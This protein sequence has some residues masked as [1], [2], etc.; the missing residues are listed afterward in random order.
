MGQAASSQW[1]MQ[2]ARAATT[3]HAMPFATCNKAVASQRHAQKPG[4]SARSGRGAA[5]QAEAATSHMAAY[6]T[7]KPWRQAAAHRQVARVDE[8]G[9]EL[10][11]RDDECLAVAAAAE[12]LGMDTSGQSGVWCPRRGGDRNKKPC[13]PWL[14]HHPQ[15]SLTVMW[16]PAALCRFMCPTP[17]AM[18]RFMHDAR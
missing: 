16:L 14:A 7:F 15:S 3:E 1:G 12:T 11:G 10:A 18:R 8:L 4:S 2:C 6:R 17:Q 9:A 13:C 5:V